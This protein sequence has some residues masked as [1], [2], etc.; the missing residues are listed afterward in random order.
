MRDVAYVALGSNL[1]D[2]AR[3]LDVARDAIASLPHTRVLAV[4]PAEETEPIEGGPP[5]QGRYLNQM[6][7][8]ETELEPH[9]LLTALQRI[10]ADAGRVRGERWGART[11]DLDIVK[12][13]SQ[14]VA[15]DTLV[16]PHRELPRRDFWQRELAQLEGAS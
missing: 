14:R 12:F 2:R 4:T 10:E 16:V 6:L 15:T 5:G 1:G 7:A 13:D 9:A 3:H 8:I 11:L